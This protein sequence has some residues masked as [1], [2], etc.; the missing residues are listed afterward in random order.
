MALDVI[1]ISAEGLAAYVGSG[2]PHRKAVA[3]SP[4]AAQMPAG[5]KD[6]ILHSS[7]E[8]EGVM[9]LASDMNREPYRPGNQMSICIHCG[10]EKEIT[11]FY[12]KLSE[13]GQVTEPL[14][15][16]FWGALY[17]EFTDRFGM[18]WLLNYDRNHTH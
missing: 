4:V 16:Q 18:R 14:G 9:L 3:E 17:A 13:G 8:R 15:E 11:E 5:M 10:S 1:D 12:Q 6:L 7:L 2:K